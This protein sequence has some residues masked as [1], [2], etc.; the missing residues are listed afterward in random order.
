VIA[1]ALDGQGVAFG[2]GNVHPKQSGAPMFPIAGVRGGDPPDDDPLPPE[3][4]IA[5]EAS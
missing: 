5:I 4:G 1:G 2:P 3:S